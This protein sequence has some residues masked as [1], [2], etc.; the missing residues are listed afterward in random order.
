MN[1]FSSTEAMKAELQQSRQET[2][3]FK[4]LQ[5]AKMQHEQ[6]L[7]KL[8][9]TADDNEFFAQ[10]IEENLENVDRAIDGMNV[11]LQQ[12]I[13]WNDLGN[14]IREEAMYGNPI[15]KLITSL[16]LHENM[17]TLRLPNRVEIYDESSLANNED[18]VDDADDA[19]ENEDEDKESEI[20]DMFDDNDDNNKQK[21]KKKEDSKIN[22]QPIEIK[23]EYHKVNVYLTMSGWNNAK[24]YYNQK[25]TIG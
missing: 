24:W 25:K 17:I 3:A 4:S 13:N 14:R 15:A 1:F 18:N 2:L 7:S 23:T 12:G 21:T 10:L 5:K 20:S 16:K 19:E 6:R 11:L 22:L 9:S 8:Q